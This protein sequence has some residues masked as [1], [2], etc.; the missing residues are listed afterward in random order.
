MM[1]SRRRFVG[2]LS[3]SSFS[4][5]VAFTI[6]HAEARFQKLHFAQ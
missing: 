1:G 4:R 5:A 2:S 3:K 6:P